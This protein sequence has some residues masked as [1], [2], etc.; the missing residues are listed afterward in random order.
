MESCLEILVLKEHCAELT[1]FPW[2][3][4]ADV[5]L[6]FLSLAKA[7]MWSHPVIIIICCL[8]FLC[9]STLTLD[10]RAVERVWV[11]GPCSLFVHGRLCVCATGPGLADMEETGCLPSG[12]LDCPR[13]VTRSKLSN[14]F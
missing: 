14:C 5:V 12:S 4:S 1:S 7:W 2:Q 13:K 3:H 9:V 11:Q 8:R 10:L 6:C